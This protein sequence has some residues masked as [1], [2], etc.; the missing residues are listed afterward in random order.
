MPMRRACGRCGYQSVKSR[1]EMRRCCEDDTLS[2]AQRVTA[3]LR[4]RHRSWPGVRAC[5]R[6][7][8]R[9]SRAWLVRVSHVSST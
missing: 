4:V 7:L 8:R 2:I 5:A 1:R 6:A 9:G 3:R